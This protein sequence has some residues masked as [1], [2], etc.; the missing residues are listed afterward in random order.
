[1]IPRD[2]EASVRRLAR[3]F[4]IVAITGPRQSG[5]STLARST[6]PE[7]PYVTLEDLDER[8]FADSDPRS[9]LARFPDGA[10]LD[11]IQRCPA[12][13]SYLQG[14]VD[15]QRQMGAFVLT[16]S[17]QP[18]L[19]EGLSQSLAGRVGIV[20]LL[21]FT[22]SEL[23]GANVLPASLDEL[24]L[25]GGYPPIYDRAIDPADFFASYVAT[26]VERD[27]RQLLAVRDLAQLQR[28]VAMCAART[29]QLLNVT[30]LGADAGLSDGTARSW[31]SVLEASYIVTRLTPHHRNLG[32]RL[33][34]TPKLYF[35]DVG[36]AAFLLGIRDARML[37]VHPMRGALFETWVVSELVKKRRNQARPLDLHFYRNQVGD[38]VDVL[39]ESSGKLHGIEIKSGA[40]FVPDWLKSLRAW[41]VLARDEV[42]TQ[43]LVYGGDESYERD[44]VRVVSWRDVDGI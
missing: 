38:E 33:V 28:F 21:P 23:R 1:M 30:S 18:S 26:Y 29:G 20:E 6:F 12:L 15:T 16:G 40:T 17:H 42:G 27:V 22:I 3:A 37:S 13:L 41:R 9:F 4:P 8:A 2:A 34:K 10:V 39:F 36:L 32:K 14:R 25:A 31:I 11:E 24:L 5:K 7:K 44:G 19:L 35:L 43:T